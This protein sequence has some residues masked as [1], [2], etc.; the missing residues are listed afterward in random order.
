M[1]SVLEAYQSMCDQ[2]VG[3]SMICP[4]TLYRNWDFNEFEKYIKSLKLQY[5]TSSV[6]LNDSDECGDYLFHYGEDNGI[7][8]IYSQPTH[9]FS[10]PARINIFD[11][12]YEY[13][14]EN[15]LGYDEDETF[16]VYQCN[17]MLFKILSEK[18]E[19]IRKRLL[20]E[21]MKNTDRPSAI[22]F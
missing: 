17:P 19:N 10:F 9:P 4:I 3:S 15:T 21:W 18:N 7:Y 13:I 16:K 5:I 11:P 14:A 20:F 22:P 8:F 2:F 12:I 1:I 6:E